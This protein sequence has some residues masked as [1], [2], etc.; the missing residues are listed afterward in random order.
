MIH[1]SSKEE[2]LLTHLQIG[3]GT[4]LCVPYT[5]QNSLDSNE[6]IVIAI[7][8]SN[9]AIVQIEVFELYSQAKFDW[10]DNDLFHLKSF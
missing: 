7:F 6:E 5:Y 10:Y 9:I 8:D 2:W 1:I 4:P 3:H